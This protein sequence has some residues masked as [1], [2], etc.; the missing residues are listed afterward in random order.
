[1]GMT[2][3]CSTNGSSSPPRAHSPCQNVWG[4]GSGKSPRSKSA[5]SATTR[6]PWPPPARARAGNK[7]WA[8]GLKRWMRPSGL[9]MSTASWLISST[10]EYS[11]ISWSLSSISASSSVWLS[12][13]WRAAVMVSSKSLARAEVSTSLAARMC[14]NTSNSWRTRSGSAGCALSTANDTRTR[15]EARSVTTSAVRGAALMMAISP[16]MSPGVCSVRIT[17]PRERTDT[18]PSRRM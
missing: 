18:S 1:M 9:V 14:E 17:P 8:A 5:A 15:R 12:A 2:L 6:W 16:M 3:T 10:R 7:R 11:V 4:A 13:S